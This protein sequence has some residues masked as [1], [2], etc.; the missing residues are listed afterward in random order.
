MTSHAAILGLELGIPV[1]VNAKGVLAS[2][3]ENEI[4]TVD[5]RRGRVYRGSTAVI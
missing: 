3:K 5:G 1:V 2:I 4:I